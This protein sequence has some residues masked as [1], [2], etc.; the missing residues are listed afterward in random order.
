MDS[1]FPTARIV[2][3]LVSVACRS[4]N[5]SSKHSMVANAMGV[6]AREPS[7]TAQAKNDHAGG[8]DAGLDAFVNVR[9]DALATVPVLDRDRGRRAVDGYQ[10]F[11]SHFCRSLAD[12][13][14]LAK[15]LKEDVGLGGD[16]D[17]AVLCRDV[18]DAAKALASGSFFEPDADE[19][20]LAVRSGHDEAAGSAT[21]ALMRGDGTAYRL[22]EHMVSGTEFE[23]RL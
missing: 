23:G 12:A 13:G 1:I 6:E 14:V 7:A 8:R 9:Q 15:Q 21:L 4:E 10:E 17:E 16:A 20:L 22:I 5:P 18:S 19:V 11:L 3:C 2:A